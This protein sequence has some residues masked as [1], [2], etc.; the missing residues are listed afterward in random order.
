M[1]SRDGESVDRDLTGSCA[2][3]V[4]HLDGL[5]P[6][7]CASSGLLRLICLIAR[8]PPRVADN[9]GCARS[10]VGVGHTT[11]Y[12]IMQIAFRR[13]FQAS[14]LSVCAG[15]FAACQD[16]RPAITGPNSRPSASLSVAT[17]PSFYYYQ[18]KPINLNI[19]ST[20]LIVE[21]DDQSPSAAATGVLEKLGISINDAGAM[22]QLPRHRL[23]KLSGVSADGALRAAAALRADSRFTF[24]SAAYVSQDGNHPVILLDQLAVRFKP[25][26]TTAQIDSMNRALG[27]HTISPPRLDSGYVAWRLAYPATAEPLEVAQEVSKS[28]IVESATPDFV[29]DIHPDYVPSDPFYNQQFYLKNTNTVGGVPVDINVEPAWNLTR[30]SNSIHVTIIDD[31]LD[32]LHS[33]SGSGYEGDLIAPFGGSMAYDMMS[34]YSLPGE[35]PYYPCCNDTHGTSVGGIIAASQD[36]GNGGAGIAPGVILNIVRIFRRTYPPDSYSGTQAASC[37]QT[38]AAI[39]WAW[40]Y[41]SSDVINNSWGGG[42][43]CNELTNAISDAQSKGRGGKGSV[44]VFA[45]G[46]TSSREEGIIGSV[47]Y[48]ATLTTSLNIISVSA[49]DRYGLAADYAPNGPIDVV[50]PSG[51]YTGD[52][53][54]EVV[55]IDRYGAPGCNDG[56]NGDENFTSTFSGTS[57]AAPQVSGV[58]AL[59]LSYRPS[60]TAA[61][62]KANIKASA[63]PWGSA[64]T[65]G[66]GKLNAYKALIH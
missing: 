24:A 45:A 26:T 9:D 17:A 4:R 43:P 37:V 31:G 55:T 22:A 8:I 40:Q 29:T 47:E 59:M 25:G 33:N 61:Q 1:T 28:A 7:R 63:D 52:C 14:L 32:I 15:F 19:D 66:S 42:A 56:P 49:I 34:S 54:G 21:T 2:L 41:A 18:G 48:P 23:L 36:N 64:S 38:A 13:C 39:N 62:V 65:F 10:F 51:R 57:A 30:G 20:K 27:T 16:S 5:T 6:G 35:S 46:N 50:V 58:A 53:I 12:P 60:L 44:V 3:P 11:S